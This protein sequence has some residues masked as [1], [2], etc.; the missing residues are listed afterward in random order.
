MT[1]LRIFEKLTPA[2]KRQAGKTWPI[3]KILNEPTGRLVQI[4]FVLIL[5]TV[6]VVLTN[7]APENYRVG[8]VAGHTVRADREIYVSDPA[9]TAEARLEAYRDAVPLFTLD[10]RMTDMTIG[11]IRQLFRQGREHLADPGRLPDEYI[12]DFISF[13]RG[14]D[15]LE[16]LSQTESSGFRE[17]LERA[18]AWLSLELLTQG[19]L[20]DSQDYSMFTGRNVEVGRTGLGFINLVPFNSLLTRTRAQYLVESRIRL[21]DLETSAS[22]GRLVGRLVLASI[23]PNLVLDQETLDLKRFQAVTS[24]DEIRYYVA[25]GEVL[26]REGEKVTP[27]I[28]L[29]LNAL[30]E[31]AAGRLWLR[32]TLG[33]FLIFLVFLAVSQTVSALEKKFLFTNRELILVMFLLLMHLFMTWSAG[34]LGQGLARSFDN[35]EV[36]TLFMAMP[37]ATVAIIGAIF[38]GLRRTLFISFIGALLG[39]AVAPMDSM[40]AFVYVINGSMIAIWRLKHISERGRL[41]PA[42][43]LAAAVNCLTITGITLLSGSLFTKQ[44]LFDLDAALLSGLLS[45]IVASGLVPFFEMT[46]GFSTNLKLMELGNLNRPILRDLMLAAPGTYHHSVIVGS[47]VEAAA[48]AI[49]ANPHLARVGAYYHDIGKVKKPLY[50]IENQMGENRHETL[51]PTMSALVLTGHVKDG[52]EMARANSLPKA[53]IDIIEQHHGTSLMSFFYHKARENRSPNSP[54]VNEGDFRYPGPKPAGKEAGLVMLADICEAAT[55]SLTDPTPTKIREL[56]KT[57]INRVFDDGQL[58]ASELILKDV[59]ETVRVF[60]N[61]LVGIYHHRIAYPMITKAAQGDQAAKSKVIY[62][63]LSGEQAKRLTH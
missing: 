13:F 4:I 5:S 52:V 35:I 30:R 29:K 15:S 8:A 2:K 53:V 50:F 63:H 47:M 57:L 22:H 54:A 31:Q 18:V 21:M 25:P 10:E 46:L 39:A 43:G 7:P 37:F 32:K 11:K 6:T 49:G 24:V 59:T 23:L 60:N 34:R 61:I 62:G 56:V 19:I 12:R 45:G 33:L 1:W 36:H 20:D 55:R 17:S 28:N 48:E 26:I 44:F 51:T 41:I 9:A 40:T 58:E 16:L 38:L 42:A 27:L 3:V 14:P